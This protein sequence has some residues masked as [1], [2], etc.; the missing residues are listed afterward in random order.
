MYFKYVNTKTRLMCRQ[1]ILK[2]EAECSMHKCAS[3]FFKSTVCTFVLPPAI[4]VQCSSMRSSRVTQVRAGRCAT[5]DLRTL[6]CEMM[7]GAN[8]SDATGFH[9]AH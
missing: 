5:P 8:L 1:C 4:E 7:Q 9:C 3:S 2:I 6:G